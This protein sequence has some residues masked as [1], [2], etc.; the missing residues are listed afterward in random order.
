VQNR[1]WNMTSIILVEKRD[2]EPGHPLWQRVPTRDAEGRYLSDFM[3]LIPKLSRWPEVRRA[4]VFGELERVLA[5]FGEMVVFADLNL[6]LNLLW[7]SMRQNPSGCLG[8]AAAI[9]ERIPEAVLVASQAEAMAGMAGA[10]RRSS[11]GWGR[12]VALL[13]WKRG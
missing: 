7:I 10:S 13:P 2:Y 8:L 6:K 12:L 1:F 4:Q 3:M 9:K 5:E 11:R